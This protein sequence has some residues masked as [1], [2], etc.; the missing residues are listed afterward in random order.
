MVV[1]VFYSMRNRLFLLDIFGKISFLR[2]FCHEA[3]LASPARKHRKEGKIIP[4]PRAKCPGRFLWK[5]R[6]EGGMGRKGP[7]PQQVIGTATE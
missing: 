4:H 1:P 7:I 2:P 6:K 3:I 5:I